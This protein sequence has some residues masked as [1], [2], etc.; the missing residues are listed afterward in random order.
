MFTERLSK[1]LQF[2]IVII[3]SGNISAIQSFHFL[4]L[5]PAA[6]LQRSEAK[7]NQCWQ[8]HTELYF[9]GQHSI[10]DEL[11]GDEEIFESFDLPESH[12]Q[13]EG[14]LHH[15]PPQHFTVGVLTDLSKSLLFLLRK[16]K[17]LHTNV[18]MLIV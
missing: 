5:S 17:M 3:I 13:Q 8:K 7:P 12:R 4:A 16:K 11:L 10:L 15:S 9:A 14:G 6:L 18:Q 2:I 1:F